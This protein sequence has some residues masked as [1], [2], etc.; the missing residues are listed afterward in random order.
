M[1]MY[2][3]A[4]NKIIHLPLHVILFLKQKK[5]MRVFNLMHSNNLC[6]KLV[7]IF[8]SGKHFQIVFDVDSYKYYIK[9]LRLGSGTFKKITSETVT[10]NILT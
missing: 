3:L 2:F 6:N 8:Y 5:Q 1:D 10:S 9:D 4:M 7:F